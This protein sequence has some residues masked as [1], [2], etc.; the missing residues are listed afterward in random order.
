MYRIGFIIEQALGHITH[1][2]NLQAN[3]P[4]DRE[5][6]AKWA[7]PAFETKGLGSKMP[8]YNSNWTVR[9]GWQ[10]RRAVADMQRS[11]GVDGLFFHTQVT[12]VLATNWIRRI[13][14]IVSLDATPIQY[15]TLGDFYEHESGSGW[16]EQQ[17]YRLNKDCFGAAKHIVSWSNYAKRGLSEYDVAPEK[18]T[19]IPPGVIT[20][21]WTRPEPRQLQNDVVKIL[22]VGGNFARKGGDILLDAFRKLSAEAT[23]PKLEL[24]LVTRD[25]IEP[26]KNVFV[27]NNMQ[28]N[29]TALKQLYFDSDIFCLPTDGDFSPM[30]LS[31]A[32]AAGLPVVSTDITAI[33]EIVRNGETGFTVKPKDSD[34]LAS[35]LRR[36]IIDPALRLKLGAQATHLART[37]FDAERNA[38]RL[39]SLLK[40]TIQVAN[41]KQVSSYLISERAS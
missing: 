10:A 35:A 41:E 33:P 7:F 1:G 30:V 2:K 36:L 5:I 9:A 34:A 38:K 32:G 21:D 39:L 26:E 15:D 11:G 17:K 18:V 23:S 16:V 25:E 19:V 37:S 29:S 40:R 6:D 3:V 8:L 4:H 28:P 31:E 13:P 22:F 14:S 20:K 12:A 24:H 27:Y